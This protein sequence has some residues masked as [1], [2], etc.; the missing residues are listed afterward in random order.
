MAVKKDKDKDKGKGKD[1]AKPVRASWLGDKA[2]PLIQGYT[3][4]LGTFLEA[5]ADGGL[6]VIS[7]PPN[8]FRCP[9]GPYERASLI[10][11]YLKTKKPRSKLIVLDAKVGFDDN[12]LFRHKDIVALRDESSEGRRELIDVHCN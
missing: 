3:E 6:V 4:R 10:A 2:T 5:M 9:P 11:H 7:A 1:K 12:A 8:P